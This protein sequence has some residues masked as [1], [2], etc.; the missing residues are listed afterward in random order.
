MIR[1]YIPIVIVMCVLGAL[2]PTVAFTQTVVPSISNTLA[3]AQI[4]ENQVL[5]VSGSLHSEQNF[6]GIAY[7]VITL[8]GSAYQPID[9]VVASDGFVFSSGT[10]EVGYELRFDLRVLPG[11]QDQL[12]MT[13]RDEQA[14]PLDVDLLVLDESSIFAHEPFQATYEIGMCRHDGEID[15]IVCDYTGTLPTQFT[16]E[17]YTDSVYGGNQLSQGQYEVTTDT[18]SFSLP[19]TPLPQ[20][21]GLYAFVVRED[22]GR[23]LFQGSSRVGA[24]VIPELVT[25]TQEAVPTSEVFDDSFGIQLVMLF[26]GFILLVVLASILLMSQSKHKYAYALV[27]TLV[28]GGGGYWYVAHALVFESTDHSQYRYHIN[29]QEYRN[30]TYVVN[31]SA[32]DTYTAAPPVSQQLEITRNG[33]DWE[34]LVDDQI[35]S[36]AHSR[37]IEILPTEYNTT[38]VRVVNGCASYY[39]FSE[40]THSVWGTYNCPPIPFN[41]DGAHVGCMDPTADNYDSD[42][43]ISGHCVYTN[44]LTGCTDP[45]ANNYDPQHVIEDG[46]CTYDSCYWTPALPDPTTYCES[47]IYYQTETCTGATRGIQG[48][49]VRSWQPRVNASDICVG[50]SVLQTEH[51]SGIS[52]DPTRVINGTGTGSSC[53]RP[54]TDFEVSTNLVNWTTCDAIGRLQLVRADQPV[55]VRSIG[56]DR[57]T[58][59]AVSQVEGEIAGSVSLHTD[60]IARIEFNYPVVQKN[61]TDVVIRGTSLAGNS[62]QQSCNVAVFDFS[63]EER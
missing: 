47:E 4:D 36:W 60:E 61:Y 63:F 37:I 24:V 54:E 27:V 62:A 40:Y 15:L 18:E 58:E 33:V 38:A 30:N 28:L 1:A 51:C 6:T 9:Q 20:K 42:A 39:A 22:T 13:W 56:T 5:T 34:L 23:V 12:I 53:I 14:I 59:W 55:Y 43:T 2:T 32:L 10:Q 17:W 45:V 50:Y 46:S 48:V 19:T 8:Q 21:D 49:Q 44:A 41:E 7:A 25:T 31:F 35:G 16:V 26:G 29:F 57:I 52:P 3:Q 11:E